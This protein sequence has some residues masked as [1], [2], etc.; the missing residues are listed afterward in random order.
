MIEPRGRLRR[1]CVV[2]AAG[3]AVAG[4]AGAGVPGVPAAGVFSCANTA[5]AASRADWVCAGAGARR[6]AVVGLVAELE[7]A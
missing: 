2:D 4:V 5:R 6:D 7:R 1:G 3:E